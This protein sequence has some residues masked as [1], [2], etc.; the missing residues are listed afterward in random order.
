VELT[1]ALLFDFA[2]EEFGVGFS[3]VG[4]GGDQIA[5]AEK[6]GKVF[7]VLGGNGFLDNLG[8]EVFIVVGD[9][10]ND[11]FFIAGHGTSIRQDV[12]L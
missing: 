4:E 8:I 11:P 9:E 7:V 2:A 1:E 3:V 10:D 5:A 12:V 6:S